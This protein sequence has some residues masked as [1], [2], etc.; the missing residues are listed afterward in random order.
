MGILDVNTI[1]VAA[2]ERVETITGRASSTYGADVMTG[3]VNII[4][5]DDFQGLELDFH[6]EIDEAALL[7]TYKDKLPT[8]ET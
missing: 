7:L 5:K 3:V 2:I 8:F 1:P 6:A 4:M